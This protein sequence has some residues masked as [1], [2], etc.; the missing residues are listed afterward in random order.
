MSFKPTGLT[1]RFSFLDGGETIHFLSET[2]KDKKQGIYNLNKFSYDAS[3]KDAMK[4]L[5]GVL[6]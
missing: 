6:A 3:F 1:F 5:F 4:K 2:K